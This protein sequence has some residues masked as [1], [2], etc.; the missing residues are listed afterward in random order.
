MNR[1][2]TGNGRLTRRGILRAGLVA[3]AGGAGLAAL[4]GCG[5]TQI[6]EVVKEV[7]VEKV[8]TREVERV[9]V[10]EKVVTQ[11]KIVTKIVEAMPAKRETVTV[12]WANWVA[13]GP[14]LA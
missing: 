8:V 11:E 4:A 2:Q 1:Q 12:R 13:S 6:V 9:V 5:E 14:R 3:G 7:P 10:Q